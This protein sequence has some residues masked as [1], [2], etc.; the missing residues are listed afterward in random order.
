MPVIEVK[1]T[2]VFARWLAGLRDIVARRRIL[3]RIARIEMGLLG[4]VKTLGGGLQ[5]IRVDHGSGYRIY[6]I[7]RGQT[8]ILLLCGGDKG[9]QSRDIERARVMAGELED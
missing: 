9:S 6:F 3:Q 2:V 8:I 7:Y 1:E 4:N 5:E